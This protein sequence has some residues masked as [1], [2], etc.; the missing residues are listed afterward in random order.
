M[1]EIPPVPTPAEILTRRS[2]RLDNVK[3][4]HERDAQ[5]L[6]E[7]EGHVP[8]GIEPVFV[9]KWPHASDYVWEWITSEDTTGRLKELWF[10]DGPWAGQRPR[11]IEADIPVGTVVAFRNFG[12]GVQELD[13]DDNLTPADIRYRVEQRADGLWFGRWTP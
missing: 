5:R 6:A 9:Q 3:H 11:M 1:T 10:A 2:Y 13:E 7:K 4:G 12:P 8:P